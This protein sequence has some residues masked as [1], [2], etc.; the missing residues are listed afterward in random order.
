MPIDEASVRP[1]GP[2]TPGSLV[3]VQAGQTPGSIESRSCALPS[4]R[5]IP[6]SREMSP[7]L[8]P[9]RA[10]SYADAAALMLADLPPC[11]RPRPEEPPH[12]AAARS[13]GI[14]GS[15]DGPASGAAH[16]RA[17]LPFSTSD[18]HGI[19]LV[20][21]DP[22][23]GLA[24]RLPSPSPRRSRVSGKLPATSHDEREYGGWVDS[25]RIS[26]ARFRIGKPCSRRS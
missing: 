6:Q 20:G 25:T 1:T 23:L 12:L 10:V 9:W 8:Q 17:A 16:F 21:R 18:R 4:D 14:V 7:W 3:Q 2:R 19:Y 13:R 24:S 26:D 22:P 5:D 11:R 15:R